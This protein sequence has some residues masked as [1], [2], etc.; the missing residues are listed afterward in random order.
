MGMALVNLL[1]Q[2][3]ERNGRGLKARDSLFKV[4]SNFRA[5]RASLND[6]RQAQNDFR[7]AIRLAPPAVAEMKRELLEGQ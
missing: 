1:T 7:D 4:C 5:K 6:V 3:H 2:I